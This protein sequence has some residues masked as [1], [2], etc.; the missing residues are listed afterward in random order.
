MLRLFVWLFLFTN[1]PDPEWVLISS[2][3]TDCGRL[4]THMDDIAA[5]EN[6]ILK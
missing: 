1:P 4:A 6:L 3:A 5:S 2:A